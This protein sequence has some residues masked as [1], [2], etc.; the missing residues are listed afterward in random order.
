MGHLDSAQHTASK[1]L[2]WGLL[3]Y[4][5]TAYNHTNQSHIARQGD[6]IMKTQ[7]T[8]V[9]GITTFENATQTATKWHNPSLGYH[10]QVVTKGVGYICRLVVNG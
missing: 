6:L 1:L 4:K 3:G 2:A 5:H 10:T 8:T 7:D 9:G